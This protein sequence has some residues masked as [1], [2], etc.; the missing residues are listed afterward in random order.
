M[1]KM[2]VRAFKLSFPDITFSDE[3]LITHEDLYKIFLSLDE[4][5]NL[6]N[7]EL[8]EKLLRFGLTIAPCKS[9]RDFLRTII[10]P[11]NKVGGSRLSLEYWTIRGHSEENSRKI[12]SQIQKENSPRSKEYWKKRGYSEEESVIKV[13]ETQKENAVKFHKAA[14]KNGTEKLLTSFSKEYWISKGMSEEDAISHVK[15]EQRRRGK[16]ATEKYTKEELKKQ[17]IFC[18]EYWLSRGKSLEDY[19]NY[20]GSLTKYQSKS[21]TNFLNKLH[22]LIPSEKVYY[23]NREY[24]KYIENYGYVRYDYVDLDLMF[25]VEYDGEYWHSSEEAKKHDSIKQNHIEQLGFKFF[26]I[27]ER[28]DREDGELANKLAEKINAHCKKN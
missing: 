27:S 11:T 6:E 14:R 18:P 17:K 25:V 1:N 19:E 22:D 12:I 10:N 23:G 26:R 3:Y 9:Y 15:S 20:M 13:S 24:G 8:C 16:W 28:E 7:A 5:L 4:N 21:A 2:T